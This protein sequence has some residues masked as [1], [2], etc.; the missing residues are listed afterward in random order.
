[1]VT[2]KKCSGQ[3]SSASSRHLGLPNLVR[4][5]SDEGMITLIPRGRGRLR[6]ASDHLD[7]IPGTGMNPDWALQVPKLGDEGDGVDGGSDGNGADSADG[8]GGDDG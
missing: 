2:V 6:G 1:M 4:V 8:D 5:L 3:G 7:G